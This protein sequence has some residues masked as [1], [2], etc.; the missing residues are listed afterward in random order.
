L[1]GGV[2]YGVAK[3]AQLVSVRVFGCDGGAEASTVISA[4]EWSIRDRLGGV[5]LFP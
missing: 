5:S 1:I 2:N 3:K 4:V